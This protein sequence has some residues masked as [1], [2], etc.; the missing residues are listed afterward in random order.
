M[1]NRAGTARG[2]RVKKILENI[3]QLLIP[4][5][6]GKLHGVPISFSDTEVLKNNTL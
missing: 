5:F 1:C 6:S 4:G 2:S 3:S